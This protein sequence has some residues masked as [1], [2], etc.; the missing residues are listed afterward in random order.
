MPSRLVRRDVFRFVV[1]T[2]CFLALN[3][4]LAFLFDNHFCSRR[5]THPRSAF[6]KGR[7]FNSGSSPLEIQ[8]RRPKIKESSWQRPFRLISCLLFGRETHASTTQSD[9]LLL[10]RRNGPCQEDVAL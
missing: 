9:P 10:P 2:L 3:Q 4:L 8:W 5:R 7:T 6:V 1:V